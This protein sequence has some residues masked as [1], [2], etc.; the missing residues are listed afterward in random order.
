LLISP[1][2]SYAVGHHFLFVCFSAFYTTCNFA[3]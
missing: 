2:Y 1:G 3:L